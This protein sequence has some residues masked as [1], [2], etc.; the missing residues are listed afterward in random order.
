MYLFRTYI[1]IYSTQVS[2][3]RNLLA[4]SISVLVNSSPILGFL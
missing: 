3:K 2:I 4:V 1:I